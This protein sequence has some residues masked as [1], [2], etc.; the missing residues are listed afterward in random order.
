MKVLMLSDTHGK[1]DYIP[2]DWLP[3][4]DVII[5]AGD[6]SNIGR[7]WEIE[8]FLQWFNRLPYP[9][10]IFIA[11][12]HDWG[13]QERR[14]EIKEMLTGYP[15]IVYLEDSEVTI[16]GLKFYGSPWQPWF[17]DWAF[18]LKRGDQL[19]E[20]WNLIPTDVD[21]LI[22]H[23]PPLEILD[24]VAQG[25]SAKHVGCDRLA[26]CVLTQLPN[27][28][29][30]VFGH[31]HYSYGTLFKDAKYFVNAATLNEQYGVANK[32]ILLEI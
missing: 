11:G 31:I 9:H 5:H 6:V 2:N 16:D 10:K 7:L 19:E 22:T 18:N 4:A 15:D 28:K 23:G 21:V 30:H 14:D 20:K 24:Y 8:E 32:P 1:H 27:L 12:N 29:L 13:F 3:E 17:Y 25:N 26:A